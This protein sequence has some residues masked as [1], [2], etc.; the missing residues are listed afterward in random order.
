VTFEPDDPNN[1]PKPDA[2]HTD[3]FDIVGLTKRAADT[4]SDGTKTEDGNVLGLTE[5]PSSIEDN[6]PIDAPV[7]Q[8]ES[9]DQD[10]QTC[11]YVDTITVG[12]PYKKI[13]EHV[14]KDLTQD[15]CIQYV[16]DHEKR[17]YDDAW[18]QMRN[19]ANDIKKL[20]ATYAR[21]ETAKPVK[22]L[23]TVGDYDEDK[24]KQKIRD[25]I[26]ARYKDLEDH[27][28]DLDAIAKTEI[29]DKCPPAPQ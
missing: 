3:D 12:I 25:L 5:V 21:K 16:K 14:A 7:K 27:R 24:I 11:M 28:R 9:R 22:D 10:Y 4:G 1:A 29:K 15:A 20:A 17:H 19:I 2:P 13:L 23:F 6:W 26:A 8:A 18:Q